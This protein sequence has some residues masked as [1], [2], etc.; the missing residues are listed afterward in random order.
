MY[1]YRYG[2]DTEVVT[3]ILFLMLRDDLIQFFYLFGNCRVSR[4]INSTGS[5]DMKAYNG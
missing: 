5:V 1:A 2:R 4:L 3:V